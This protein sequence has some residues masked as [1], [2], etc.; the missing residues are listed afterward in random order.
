MNEG[1]SVTTVQFLVSANVDRATNDVRNAASSVQSKLPTAAQSPVI[2]RVDATGNAILT[3]ALEAP[4]KT[5]EE[6]SWL[7]D[8]DDRESPSRRKGRFQD[9][10]GWRRGSR[11]PASARRLQVDGARASPRPR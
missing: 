6:Q 7:V 4:A 10:A 1:S 2:Q 5:M 9:R 8:N 11:D 3:F